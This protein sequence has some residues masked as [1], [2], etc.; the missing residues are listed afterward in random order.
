[1]EKFKEK[2]NIFRKFLK[3]EIKRNEGR[4]PT[5]WKSENVEI[6][7]SLSQGNRNSRERRKIKEEKMW[8]DSLEEKNNKNKKK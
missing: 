7:I 8:F 6:F 5:Q 3:I 4:K 2:K 1:M